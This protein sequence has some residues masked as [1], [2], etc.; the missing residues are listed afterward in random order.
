MV[1]TGCDYH[2]KDSHEASS[3]IRRGKGRDAKDALWLDMRA[4]TLVD[5]IQH[6]QF[7]VLLRG[8]LKQPT[9]TSLALDES[10]VKDMI[11]RGLALLEIG[12]SKKLKRPI[13]N[14]SGAGGD[15]DAADEAGLRAENA[16]LGQ[17]LSECQA[18][19]ARKEQSPQWDTSFSSDQKQLRV[20]VLA[21]SATK[22]SAAQDATR[23]VLTLTIHRRELQASVLNAHKQS[24]TATDSISIDLKT[25]SA[26]DGSR[27]AGV[28]K[29]DVTGKL[30]PPTRDPLH[31]ESGVQTLSFQLE[32]GSATNTEPIEFF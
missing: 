7:L 24:F 12:A 6:A 14:A 30:L 25:L 23:S 32:V 26:G 2:P 4:R 29:N 31:A 20:H 13:A 19:A 16:K 5:A 18:E 3:Y 21:G 15:S 10:E 28:L 27:F 11:T 17:M 1:P 22:F 8:A 9:R